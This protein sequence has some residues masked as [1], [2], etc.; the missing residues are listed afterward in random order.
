MQ[1]CH[2]L[3]S[4]GMTN[5][6]TCLETKAIHHNHRNV[7]H[8]LHRRDTGQLRGLHDLDL[9][10]ARALGLPL[11]FIGD[12][13]VTYTS[14]PSIEKR[15]AE[16]YLFTNPDSGSDDYYDDWAQAMGLP[17]GFTGSM[18]VKGVAITKRNNP[19][20]NPY[21]NNKIKLLT[22]QFYQK[23]NMFQNMVWND[24]ELYEEVYGGAPQT[25]GPLPGSWL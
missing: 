10:Y 3:A 20:H 21:G 19:M 22:G 2:F 4:L 5:L 13:V 23:R 9:A 7:P 24:P 15:D 16:D 11:G 18:P 1:T 8:A 12:S 14:Q 25:E 17:T 6:Q